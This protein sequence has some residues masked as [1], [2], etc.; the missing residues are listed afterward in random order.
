MELKI[1]RIANGLGLEG[2][3]EW[4]ENITWKAGAHDAGGT[5]HARKIIE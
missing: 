4:E 1:A 5:E 2:A 3:E